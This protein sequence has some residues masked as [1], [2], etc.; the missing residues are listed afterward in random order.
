M[1]SSS[2]S[3]LDGPCH[4]PHADRMRPDDTSRGQVA[5]G[6]AEVY[7]AFFVPALFGQWPPQLLD[8]AGAALG[9]RV[10]DVGCGTGVLAAAAAARV[11]APGH[12]AALD[13]NAGMLAVAERRA[14][15]IDWRAGVAEAIPFPD[16]VFDRVV[17]QFAV[18]FFDD[19]EA[20]LAEM[21]RVVRP[22]GTVAVA[23][24]AA[25]AESP[26]Y[27]ALIDL[28]GRACGPAAADALAAPFG[29]GAPDA[30]GALAGAAFDD[31]AVHRHV[32]WA[33]FA[34]IDA[35]VRTEIEGWTLAGSVGDDA[36]AR[37]V[38]TA[39]D[40]LAGFTDGAGRVTFPA[41]ALI[42]TGRRG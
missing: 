1:V 36:L 13:P 37:L 28:L 4:R 8:A 5:A 20:A 30:L 32:G 15:P 11:G 16:G 9:D 27:A 35:W 12:V 17:S 3:A 39:R 10:L 33:R 21:A 38:E 2:E 42:A 41:P 23:S 19:R 25:A 7:E 6:A 18:M 24:W 40:E 26:G 31:V 34:S 22:G 29:L 14:E